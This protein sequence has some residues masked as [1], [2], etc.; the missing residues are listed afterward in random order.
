MQRRMAAVRRGRYLS[1]SHSAQSMIEA[2]SV[3]PVHNIEKRMLADSQLD[4][5][6]YQG[7]SKFA[8]SEASP[9]EMIA[10]DF[11]RGFATGSEGSDRCYR[12]RNQ[13]HPAF[14]SLS[15]SLADVPFA[16]I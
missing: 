4:K 9:M 6:E 10:C 7:T 8:R 16:S 12:R 13:E 5:L 3:C 11:R 2:K 1:T 14:L 15:L